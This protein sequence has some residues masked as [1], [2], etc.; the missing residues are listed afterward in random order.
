MPKKFLLELS[1]ERKDSN[2]TSKNVE[3]LFSINHVMNSLTLVS[4]LL[5]SQLL[6]Y[7]MSHRLLVAFYTYITRFGFM[8]NPCSESIH[9]VTNIPLALYQRHLGCIN[10]GEELMV[11][12]GKHNTGP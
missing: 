5:S 10:I 12:L 7:M 9:I 2:F 3:L 6:Q 8:G 1:P 11:W 4:I